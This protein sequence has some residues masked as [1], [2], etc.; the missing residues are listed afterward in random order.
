M[1][2]RSS[3][4]AK[5]ALLL[6]ATFVAAVNH[7]EDEA[8]PGNSYIETLTVV[9]E[10]TNATVTSDDIER[11]QA[12]DLADVFRLTPSISV[13]GSVG[14]AQKIYVR[15]LE[16]ALLNV[17]VDGAPQTSTLFH[18]IG[19]VTIDPELLK[20]VEVQA[21]AGEATS[22][23]GAI[24]GAIRFQTKDAAD[25]LVDDKRFGARLKINE[26]TNDGT[27]YSA[28]VYGR[29]SD[30]WGFLAAYNDIDRENFEDGDGNEVLGTAADQQMAFVKI[31]GNISDQQR[32]SISYESRDEEGSFSARPNWI[33]QPGDTLYTSEAERETIVAN[34]TLELSEL[35]NL[36]VTGYRTES[37][38]RGGRFDW[39]SEITTNGFD[40]RNTSV[41]ENHRFTYGVDYRDDEVDSG[42]YN[43]QP[44]EDHGE[45]GSVLGIYFQGH[46]QLTDALLISYGVRYDDYDYEQ[47]ILLADYYGDPIPDSGAEQS[48]SAIS[49]NAGFIYDFNENWSAG[50]GVAQAVRGKEIGDGF[51]IDAYLYDSSTAPVVDPGL[52]L[53]SVT[54]VEASLEY[55]NDNFSAKFAIFQS[56]I[57]DV[58][59]E[60]LYGNSLY[61]NIGTVETD[62]IEV[63]LAY[64][65]EQLSLFVGFATHDAELDPASGLYANNWG[66]VDLNGYEFNGLGISRGDTWV[67]GIDYEASERL[68]LGLTV[69]HVNDLDID[70]LHQDFEFG[71]VPNVY[72]LNKP[73]YTTVDAFVDWQVT[74]YLKASLAVTN[75]FD[76]EYRDSSSVGDFSAVP[77]YELVVGPSEA[78]RDVRLTLSM[79][80]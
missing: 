23:P 43:P 66:A 40:I 27:R 21:G 26:F 8:D 46:S 32:L 76:E 17:T 6:I 48:D 49:V 61:Q 10:A 11:Y 44:E 22:G 58:I 38:F 31:S 19:R 4:A 60:R 63:D 1:F 55:N 14:V 67:V 13:G 36:E 47:K 54:N 24:G 70:T 7:A 71:W 62:G 41:I 28:S 29:L 2:E 72:R 69:T 30:N 37:S 56:D 3:L 20:E 68:Q 50:L 73:S 51:T 53:E 39:L 77:G 64:R 59:F 15:G 9:G 34:Y 18:H 57:D 25:L 16:D 35:V 12:N 45:E 78:G 42:Y 65:W 79:E 5:A 52:D 33:V 75:L 80:I 74:D